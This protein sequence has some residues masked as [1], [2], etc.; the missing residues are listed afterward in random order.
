MRNQRPAYTLLEMVLVMAIIV[1]LMA[2][3]YPS[4]EGMQVGY[5]LS[6][7]GDQV[8]AAWASARAQSVEEGRPYRFSVVLDKGNFR[9]APDSNEYW[10]G[11]EPPAPDDPTQRP[12]ILEEALPKGVRFGTPEMVQG[13]TMPRSGDS[14]LPV[15]SVEPAAWTSTVTF[16]PD[17]TTQDDVEINFSARG[18]KPLSIKL[19]ALTG[20]VTVKQIGAEGGRR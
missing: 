11:G 10:Q 20:V 5:R 8:R 16:L 17:G 18:G 15:G 19:R 6:A 4:V 7:A 14:S 3:G 1:I 2:V 12:L 13:G 9:V